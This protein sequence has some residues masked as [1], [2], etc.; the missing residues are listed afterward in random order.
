MSDQNQNV[1][2]SE[3]TDAEIA[4]RLERNIRDERGAEGAP[5]EVETPATEYGPVDDTESSVEEPRSPSITDMFAQKGSV[6]LSIAPR[7]MLNVSARDSGEAPKTVKIAG[8]HFS[9]H[10]PLRKGSGEKSSPS[11]LIRDALSDLAAYAGKMSERDVVFFGDTE[12]L[13]SRVGDLM[14]FFD[15]NARDIMFGMFGDTDNPMF[16]YPAEIKPVA[17]EEDDEEGLDAIG[18]SE[19]SADAGPEMVKTPVSESFDIQTWPVF[20]VEEDGTI[21]LRPT[22]AVNVNVPLLVGTN[23]ML[24]PIETMSKIVAN[25]ARSAGLAEDDFR[26][27]FAFD[28]GELLDSGILDLLQHY[29]QEESEAVLISTSY[30]RASAADIDADIYRVFPTG[31][32]ALE[33]EELLLS[34][35]GDTL[36]LL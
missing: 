6:R 24:K 1:Q 33:A 35:G 14:E 20:D 25:Y 36:L 3:P 27:T 31:R 4:K 19:Y 30:I 17:S 22:I 2:N 7:I 26:L 21:V 10:S 15:S 9:I 13:E 32:T 12:G 28:S 16:Q 34:N 23:N 18:V 29:A 8:E 5:E 11:G